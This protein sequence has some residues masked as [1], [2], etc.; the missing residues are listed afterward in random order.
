MFRRPTPLFGA[1]LLAF[2][3]AAIPVGASADDAQD[4]APANTA[5]V[6]I[7]Y[8]GAAD[9]AVAD[10]VQIDCGAI[11]PV[12]GLEVTCE[13]AGLSVDV[14][15]YDPDWGERALAVP[16]TDGATRTVVRYRVVLEAPPAPEVAAS[17]VDN[18]FA[19]GSQVLV[20]LSLLGISCTL[21]TADAAAVE[22]TSVTPEG[23]F[24]GVGA[25]HLAVRYDRAGDVTVGLALTD[26]AGQRVDAELTVTMVAASAD[27]AMTDAAP[28][29]LHVLMAPRGEV[30]L[31][32]LAW[33]DDVVFSCLADDLVACTPEGSATL[34]EAP[35][36]GD[37]FAFR[38]VDADGRQALGSVTFQDDVA[39]DASAP[40]PA[41]WAAEAP[42]GVRTT[43]PPDDS[44]EPGTSVLSGLSRIL[45]EVPAP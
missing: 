2:A 45:Q 35:V 11:G 22:V 44:G 3:L 42:L 43:P 23:A 31:T 12:D 28:R 17:R 18:P 37:Q 38:A 25:T 15:S 36:A 6:A 8:D 41:A 9:I 24:A 40:V 39:A 14:A 4:E 7:P 26:D 16:F 34:R 33:G 19:A 5:V 10:G 20:P 30:D 21:C 27:D 13:P 32:A 1:G 29:A